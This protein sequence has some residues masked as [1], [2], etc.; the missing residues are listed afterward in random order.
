[1]YVMLYTVRPKLV[2]CAVSPLADRADKFWEGDWEL[3]RSAAD[4]DG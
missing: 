2:L 3:Q 4:K 1:M